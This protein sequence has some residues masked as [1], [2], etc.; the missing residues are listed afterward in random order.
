M[1]DKILSRLILTVA[2]KRYIL[3]RETNVCSLG[4][5]SVKTVVIGQ[6]AVDNTTQNNALEKTLVGTVTARGKF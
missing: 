1:H 4:N 2:F 6:K 5:Y 3:L